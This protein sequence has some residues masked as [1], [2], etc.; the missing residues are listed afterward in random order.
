VLAG[1]AVGRITPKSNRI[2]GDVRAG[3][4]IV[5]LASTGVHTNGLTLCRAIAE[6]L[7]DGYLTKISD[8]RTY[9]EALLDPSAIYVSFLAAAQQAG[10]KLQYAAHLTGHGW[11]KLMRLSEPFVYRMTDVGIVPPVFDFIRERGPVDLREMYATFNMG[12]G[13]AVYVD[14][15]DASRCVEIAQSVGQ[16]AWLGGTVVKD[17]AR[18]AVEIEP[19][20]IAFEG[21]TLQVR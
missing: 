5:L 9:G 17:G 3:D 7:P 13:F 4:A 16:R 19:L 1:S 15:K 21:E 18:K 12:V 8:G 2:A 6:R 14:P 11:R 20:G 10:V